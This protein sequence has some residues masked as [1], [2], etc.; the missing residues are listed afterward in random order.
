[1]IIGGCAAAR[2]IIVDAEIEIERLREITSDSEREYVVVVVV[3]LMLLLLLLLLRP[4]RLC[5][6]SPEIC[7]TPP[8]D[9]AAPSAISVAN[10]YCPFVFLAE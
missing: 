7:I 3:M 1:M 2:V 5:P 8:Q 10:S 4:L 9:L 6:D